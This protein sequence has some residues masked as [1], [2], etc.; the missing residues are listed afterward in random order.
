[1]DFAKLI[2]P[3]KI[4]KSKLASAAAQIQEAKV[5]FRKNLKNAAEQKRTKAEDKINVNET[6]DRMNKSNKITEY[7]NGVIIEEL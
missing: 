3:N 2:V 5:E 1:M 7:S 6:A 4:V